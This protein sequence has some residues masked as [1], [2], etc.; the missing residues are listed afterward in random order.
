VALEIGNNNRM[1]LPSDSELEALGRLD[2]I[3]Q[4]ERYGGRQDVA[5]RL[6]MD[7]SSA[8]DTISPN[9]DK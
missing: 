9:E 4:I 1:V 5:R 3:A 2:L 8:N 6:G 7:S